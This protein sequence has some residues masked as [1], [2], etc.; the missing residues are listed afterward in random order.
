ML[1]PVNGPVNPFAS[2]E[3]QVRKNVWTG[4]VEENMFSDHDFRTQQQSYA[5]FG[6]AKDP[7]IL[8]VANNGQSGAG[9]QGTGFVGNIER[10]EQMDGKKKDHPIRSTTRC[11]MSMILIKS[12]LFFFWIQ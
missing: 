8:S 5:A 6:Y 4:H 7:S 12:V 2:T 10:A 9:K 1:Q 11:P 3:T